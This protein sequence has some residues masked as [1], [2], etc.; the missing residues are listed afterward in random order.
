MINCSICNKECSSNAGLG[1][2]MAYMHGP[3]SETLRQARAN[4]AKGHIPAS[5][6][7]TK[8]D[9]PYLE[10]PNQRGKKFGSAISGHS[11]ETRQKI[12]KAMLGNR[13]A[14]H[15]GDRQAQYNGIRMDSKW[16]VGTAAYL[17]RQNII[18]KY[19]ERGF[20]LSNGSH[21]FP[22]FFIYENDNFVKLIEVKGYFRE[23]NKRKFEL[24]LI[25]YPH[26]CT[27]LWQR[28]KLF[29]L[30]IIDT[31]GYLRDYGSVC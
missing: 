18:W 11:T 16:E 13:N 4:K 8:E 29:E 2:H 27:E 21:Y 23:S 25:D 9:L 14:N 24:F 28:D 5:K 17:D 30:G 7:K 20:E 12:S 10:R 15:R 3:N 22:D 19:N 31:S 1:Q 6:G 26:I